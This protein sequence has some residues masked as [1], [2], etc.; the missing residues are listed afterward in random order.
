MASSARLTLPNVT[1]LPTFAV[2]GLAT[3]GTTGPTSTLPTPATGSATFRSISRG[4]T[5]QANDNLTWERGRHTLKFGFDFQQVTLYAKVT[6]NARP[7]YNFSGV[8]TQNPQNRTGTGNPL[9][10]FLLGY[11]SSSTVSTDSDSESRQH[12]YQG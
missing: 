5:I 11:T 3:I 2:T 7:S 12:I 1:G 9:A 10:D 4:R 8:Y 6:L